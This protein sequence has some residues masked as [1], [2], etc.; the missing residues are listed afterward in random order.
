MVTCAMLGLPFRFTGL[1]TLAI[2]ETDRVTAVAKELIK[3]GIL[4]NVESRDVVSWEGRR[5]PYVEL[6]ASTPTM[7]T[8]WLCAWHR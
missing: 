7:T 4:L 3:V 1:S 2:K 6:P 5:V 8:V